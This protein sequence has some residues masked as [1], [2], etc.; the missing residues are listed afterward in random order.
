MSRKKRPNPSAS[1]A[2]LPTKAQIVLV[3]GLNKAT[4]IY[5]EFDA[6]AYEEHILELIRVISEDLKAG[7]P[8]DTTVQIK[9]PRATLN[10]PIEMVALMAACAKQLLDTVVIYSRLPLADRSIPE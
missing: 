9:L 8:E 10:C 2:S 4:N 1:K 6:G 7:V 5:K 3:E